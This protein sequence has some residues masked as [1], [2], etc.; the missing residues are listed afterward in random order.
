MSLFPP[1]LSLAP[2]GAGRHVHGAWR[3]RARARHVKLAESGVPA[4]INP[5]CILGA[6]ARAQDVTR[7]TARYTRK[8]RARL[9]RV[10]RKPRSR[11][12]ERR[13]GG[14]SINFE[15]PDNRRLTPTTI[16]RRSF[17]TRFLK[18]SQ[19]NSRSAN[20][21]LAEAERNAHAREI[22]PPS[23]SSS[24]ARGIS[25]FVLKF[26]KIHTLDQL[27]RKPDRLPPP[28]PA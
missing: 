27:I 28:P 13:E 19:Q 25:R 18:L 8:Q 9:Y 22:L 2:L 11:D 17:Y 14:A 4:S 21:S 12:D 10:S 23:R 1:P 26:D 3:A 6:R 16:L 5:P 20:W 15:S 7:R 24:H